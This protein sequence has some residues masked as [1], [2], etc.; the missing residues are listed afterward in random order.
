M[1]LDYIVQVAGYNKPLKNGLTMQNIRDFERM[2][3]NPSS[4]FYQWCNKNKTGCALRNQNEILHGLKDFYNAEA[5]QYICNQCQRGGE[6]WFKDKYTKYIEPLGYL[7]K[8]KEKEEKKEKVE[9]KVITEKQ[10]AAL[11]KKLRAPWEKEVSV[12]DKSTDFEKAAWISFKNKLRSIFK[13][14]ID[15]VTYI[16]KITGNTINYTNE[17]KIY[18]ELNEFLEKMDRL[19]KTPNKMADNIIKIYGN[20]RI[21]EHDIKEGKIEFKLNKKKQ[22]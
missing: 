8:K 17:I 18:T 16:L 1:S 5:Y 21:T 6:N 9:G 14:S 22:Y 7:F 11:K 19:K 10:V 13:F 4:K 2:S 3:K 12:T 20:G 15:G